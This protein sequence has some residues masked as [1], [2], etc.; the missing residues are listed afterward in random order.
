MAKHMQTV[1]DNNEYKQWLSKLTQNVADHQFTAALK[2]NAELLTFYWQLGTEIVKYQRYAGWGEAFMVQL[3]RDLTAAFPNIK[4]F[5]VRNLHFIRRW[6]LFYVRS[7]IGKRLLSQLVLVPWAHNIRIISKSQTVNEAHFYIRNTLQHGWSRHVLAYHI[8]NG[9]WQREGTILN[10]INET[11]PTTHTDLAVQTLNDDYL[12]DFLNLTQQHKQ[13]QFK[14]KL[15]K[16][17]ISFLLEWGSGFA[18]MGK[19][20]TIKVDQQN[21]YIDLLFYHIHLRCYVVI[22][23]NLGECKPEYA[24]KLDFYIKH[25]DEQLYKKGDTPTIG[26]L[27]CQT[28]GKIMAKYAIN[29]VHKPMDIIAHR[30]TQTLPKRFKSS[31]RSGFC[32]TE[33]II[34]EPVSNLRVNTSTNDILR[35]IGNLEKRNIQHIF[36]S[37]AT[38]PTAWE[39]E[40]IPPRPCFI[41]PT[42]W[43]S[44][45]IP[46]RPYFI[47][48]TAWESEL[49]PPSTLLHT[50]H[51]VGK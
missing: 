49:I 31:L 4:G 2:V 19:Q 17:I 14:Q 35:F 12:F 30:L 46:P 11:L 21:H 5:S 44:E 40:L 47:F 3:S 43:E 24:S 42:T 22:E 23:L 33:C 28:G 51:C 1:S 8:E 25:I 7:D 32:A 9:L 37:H 6:Y 27:L 13:R 10:H 39:S 29:E 15:T 16:Q 34:R 38:F 26:I 50:T 48:P 18:Y 36:R 20:Y 41:F 45:L